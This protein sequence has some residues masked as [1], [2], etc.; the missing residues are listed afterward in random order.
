[1]SRK[2]LWF[3][4]LFVLIQKVDKSHQFLI[5]KSN[6]RLCHVQNLDDYRLLKNS[7]KSKKELIFSQIIFNFLKH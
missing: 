7:L 6:V 2:I 5:G 1:M 4:K 3:V